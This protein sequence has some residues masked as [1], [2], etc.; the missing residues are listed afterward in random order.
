MFKLLSSRRSVICGALGLAMASLSLSAKASDFPGTEPI[1]L[2]VPFPPGGLTD[3]LSRMLAQGLAEELK[4]T[5]I[6][7][8]VA[9]ATGQ[10]GMTRVARAPADGRTLVMSIGSTHVMAPALQKNLP[11]KTDQDFV[12]LGRTGVSKLVIVANPKLPANGLQELLALARRQEQPLFYGTWG[13]GSGA[14]LLMEV[15]N[16]HGKLTMTQSP[17][18]G[19]APMLNAVMGGEVLLGVASVSSA[20][21]LIRDGRIKALGV[22]G[23]PRSALLP[24]VPTMDEQGIRF[25]GSLGWFG[26]FAPAKTPAPVVDQL[27][28]ALT[29]VLARPQVQER[30]R[31]MGLE[32]ET[33][34]RAEFERQIKDDLVFWK[35]LVTT[36]R[37]E[38]P[39]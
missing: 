9:G 38:I 22:T 23:S 1:K 39:N 12:P 10:L 17:Y 32:T 14:H 7:E 11:Y 33:S 21:P 29:A 13:I 15:I 30:M 25:A 26:L 34:S 5:V 20:A 24:N 19:E 31:A 18:K 8:N 37:I 36:A 16:Q 3:S 28:K 2:V 6:V 4:G 27:S 35:D